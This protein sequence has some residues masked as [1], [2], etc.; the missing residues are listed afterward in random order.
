VINRFR[1]GDFCAFIFI[2]QLV[3]SPIATITAAEMQ[4]GSDEPKPAL[5]KVLSQAFR[6]EYSSPTQAIASPPDSLP[7][8]EVDGFRQVAGGFVAPKKHNLKAL[9]GSSNISVL[10]DV[11]GQY[12]RSM[13]ENQILPEES[14]SQAGETNL[15]ESIRAGRSF[16][17]KSLAALARTEQAQA[18]TG[19]AL[20]L[21]LPS[22]SLSASYGEETSE[23]SVVVNEKTGKLV[24]SDTH[25]RTDSSFTIRQP[26]FDLP[27][28]LEWRRR[29]VKEQAREEDYRVSDGNAYISTIKAYLSMVSSRLQADITHDFETQLADLLSYIEK[30]ADAGAA[31]IS[32]MSRVRAR[33]QETLSSRLE[34]ESAHLAAGIEFVRLTNLVP[35]KV[36]LPTLEDIGASLLPKSFDMA[37]TTA[38]K[39]NPEIAALTAELHAA[40]IEQNAAKGEY[41]PRVDLLYS[42]IHAL[43]AGGDTSDEGQR[44]QR[45]MAVLSWDLFDGGRNYKHG[46]EITARH[47]E[48]LYRLGD[49]RRSVVQELSANYAAL[50]TTM[51][52]INSGYQELEAISTAA[53][54]MSKRMLS[55]NQSLLDL[56]DVYNRYYQARSRLVK[57]HILEMNTVAQLIRTTLG[58]PWAVTKGTPPAVEQNQFSPLFNDPRGDE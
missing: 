24:P 48:L 6:T 9:V 30:R 38:M 2:L 37:V 42:N 46:V 18:Q 34:Q 40:K 1:R 10:V 36:R 54:A 23:P 12:T 28:F 35:H 19:Q 31:S 21:L 56:L 44:D 8:Q 33:S 53:E 50:E 7:A 57:L 47:R 32:D 22:V 17:R 39:S 4:I 51:E 26:L 11:D 3:L 5:S 43:H 49:Q 27:H 55:G 29:K 45:L 52:R 15:F 16:S 25:S 58:T 14:A 13:A 41:L 20:S